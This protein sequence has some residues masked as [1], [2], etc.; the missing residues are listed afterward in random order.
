[1]VNIAEWQLLI[2]KLMGILEYLTKFA[3]WRIFKLTR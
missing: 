3:A 1:M 2:N